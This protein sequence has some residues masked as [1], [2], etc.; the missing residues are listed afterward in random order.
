MGTRQLTANASSSL[1]DFVGVTKRF[2]SKAG[3]IT[4]LSDVNF[5]MP[6]GQFVS[7]VG[8][9]GCGKS[10]LLTALAGLSQPSEGE[11][12]V[13]GERIHGPLTDSG[14]VFQNSE[15]LPWR[16]A[17]QNVMLQAEIRGLDTKTY[18]KRAGELLTQVGLGGF[19]KSLPD[20]LSGG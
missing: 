12:R 14:I 9:S 11:V 7:V 13:N 3:I 20:Q 4:A 18:L 10:T 5:Q 2:E 1:V 8:P 19:E 6:E 15:L 17:I 16:T